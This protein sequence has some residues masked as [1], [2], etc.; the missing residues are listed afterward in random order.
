MLH[1]KGYRVPADL[2]LVLKTVCLLLY[3]HAAISFRP[4]P[5]VLAAVRALKRG[6]NARNP[7][8]DEKLDKV[9][10]ACN[11]FLLRL[12]GSGKPCLRRALVMY[13]F[14]CRMG[15]EAEVKIGALK[16]GGRLKGHGWLEI[17][18]EPYLENR[19]ALGRYT[20]TLKG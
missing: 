4:A 10:R 2:P 11:F 14:C 8:A 9:W 16:E 18:G 7:G 20:V 12:A 17:G 6:D 13:H 1:Y 5:A 19:Q 3:Y 15:L